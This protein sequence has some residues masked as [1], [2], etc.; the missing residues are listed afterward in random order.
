MSKKRVIVLDDSEE[1]KE[2]EGT[3][4][5]QPSIKIEDSNSSS[6]S[7]E[8]DTK[9]S[10]ST[11]TKKQQQQK[12]VKVEKKPKK[13]SEKQQQRQRKVTTPRGK[14]TVKREEEKGE[15]EDDSGEEEDKKEKKQATGRRKKEP[16]GPSETDRGKTVYQLFYSDFANHLNTNST[17][18]VKTLGNPVVMYTHLNGLVADIYGRFIRT[19]SERD[20]DL[21]GDSR[22]PS[23]LRLIKY[24]LDC[25]DLYLIAGFCLFHHVARDEQD[26][27]RLTENDAHYIALKK[28]ANRV[29]TPTLDALRQLFAATDVAQLRQQLAVHASKRDSKKVES[30]TIDE[31]LERL[32]KRL[33]ELAQDSQTAYLARLLR[34]M[35]LR[36]EKD[37]EMTLSLERLIAENRG[38][39]LYTSDALEVGKEHKVGGPTALEATNKRNWDLWE[40][41]YRLMTLDNNAWFVALI[42]RHLLAPSVNTTATVDELN[43]LLY[44][45]TAPFYTSRESDRSFVFYMTRDLCFLLR[46]LQRQHTNVA[47]YIALLHE[48]LFGA[49]SSSSS[50]STMMTS[51]S[52]AYPFDK[53]VDRQPVIDAL[54]RVMRD[55]LRYQALS[56]DNAVPSYTTPVYVLLARYE[57]YRSPVMSA[58]YYGTGVVDVVV[59]G[60]AADL[61][62]NEQTPG[63][64]AYRKLTGDTLTFSPT[65]YADDEIRDRVAQFTRLLATDTFL[66]HCVTDLLVPRFVDRLWG[67]LLTQLKRRLG[68]Y[69]GRCCS[70]RDIRLLRDVLLGT[71]TS[72]RLDTL[73]NKRLKCVRYRMPWLTKRV[74]DAHFVEVTKRVPDCIFPVNY[75]LMMMTTTG[76]GGGDSDREETLGYVRGVFEPLMKELQL[77]LC[78]LYDTALREHNDPLRY[79]SFT[80]GNELLLQLPSETTQNAA[81]RCLNETLIDFLASSSSGYAEQ[82]LYTVAD[83][84]KQMLVMCTVLEYRYEPDVAAPSVSSG[85]HKDAAYLYMKLC[86]TPDLVSSADASDTP[87]CVDMRLITTLENNGSL[88]RLRPLRQQQQQQQQLSIAFIQKTSLRWL[89]ADL[90]HYITAVTTERG[91]VPPEWKSV[92]TRITQA[93]SAESESRDTATVLSEELCYTP[94]FTGYTL[95]VADPELATVGSLKNALRLRGAHEISLTGAAFVCCDTNRRGGAGAPQTDLTQ[96]MLLLVLRSYDSETRRVTYTLLND[97]IKEDNKLLTD[98]ES[99]EA[100]QLF[101]LAAPLVTESQTTVFPQSGRWFDD[102]KRGTDTADLRRH[103]TIVIVERRTRSARASR[104]TFARHSINLGSDGGGGEEYASDPWAILLACG[105]DEYSPLGWRVVDF[106]TTR[107]SIA[108]HDTRSL[109]LIALE[110]TDDAECWRSGAFTVAQY[111]NLCDALQ[112]YRCFQSQ[113]ITETAA[114]VARTVNPKS[115]AVSEPVYISETKADE[116]REQREQQETRATKGTLMRQKNDLIDVYVDALRHAKKAKKGRGAQLTIGERKIVARDVNRAFFT[117]DEQGR[118]NADYA[119]SWATAVKEELAATI[120]QLLKFFGTLPVKTIEG[121]VDGLASKYGVDY[122][123]SYTKTDHSD[124]DYTERFRYMARSDGETVVL[125]WT[126][127]DLRRRAIESG[128]F[129]LDDEERYHEF[130]TDIEYFNRKKTKQNQSP[131]TLQDMVDKRDRDVFPSEEEYRALWEAYMQPRRF[132]VH[133]FREALQRFRGQQQQ[134]QQFEEA[135]EDDNMSVQSYGSP[136]SLPNTTDTMPPA[137]EEEMSGLLMGN[138]GV[139]GNQRATTLSSQNEL[140]GYGDGRDPQFVDVDDTYYWMGFADQVGEEP[141]DVVFRQDD[142]E[143]FSRCV[144]ATVG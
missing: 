139:D 42:H 25:P 53:A 72:Q 31:S 35:N 119:D 133:R 107:V 33:N 16:A 82:E 7:S 67:H 78:F 132:D 140:I 93:A 23:K 20:L 137:N 80:A 30:S 34:I 81:Y 79:L 49:P 63:A 50:S 105:G 47:Q 117:I 129:G 116:Q 15:D 48:V 66:Y 121:I 111:N 12:S 64:T 110:S 26:S 22:L 71:N 84:L 131:V 94:A 24:A 124:V 112:D 65:L 114:K 13:A 11:T 103:D 128:A 122:L 118:P 51:V 104:E 144:T 142:D 99:G 120:Q 77:Q 18:L 98:Y 57:R 44:T 46:E 69:A 109:V 59:E 40:L 101:I 83:R 108:K 37:T 21:P 60:L 113:R 61:R 130:R 1:E 125:D 76:G 92:K 100:E 9:K 17:A 126:L 75:P 87:M 43:E 2:D 135:E 106:V 89:V 52:G 45:A 97:T 95:R 85:L 54:E 41:Y 8:E 27:M 6:S 38:V 5:V 4:D 90:K 55:D 56:S 58:A 73:S 62:Q 91:G 143:F 141:A 39:R 74:F 127:R 138:N 32:A 134:Q 3:M 19:Y 102:L 136:V 68:L 36:Y 123:R 10:T 115:T 96:L 70:S 88:F 14:K 86:R 28:A 29:T